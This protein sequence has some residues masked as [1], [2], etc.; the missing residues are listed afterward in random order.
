MCFNPTLKAELE[1][2]LA[3]LND[4][5]EAEYAAVRAGTASLTDNELLNNCHA[6]EREL[7]KKIDAIPHRFEVGDGVCSG[8]NGDLYPYRVVSVSKSGKSIGVVP[9]DHKAARE[10]L[11]MGHQEWIVSD[12]TDADELTPTTVTLRSNGRWARKGASSRSGYGNFYP[13]AR[14]S[15]N[16][17]F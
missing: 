14:Y 6:A 11:E 10:G 15:Y 9:M 17:E 3:Q 5:R 12:R 4:D 1:L 7:K 2:E 8:G 16:W 13:G